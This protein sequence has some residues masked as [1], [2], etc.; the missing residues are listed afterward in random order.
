[1]E[2]QVFSLCPYIKCEKRSTK[3][4]YK[5]LNSNYFL[6]AFSVTPLDKLEILNFMLFAINVRAILF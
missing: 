2:L 1:M 4:I 3:N 5:T 6:S